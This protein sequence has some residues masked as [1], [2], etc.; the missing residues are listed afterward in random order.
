MSRVVRPEDFM[1]C[2]RESNCCGRRD[3]RRRGGPGLRDAAAQSFRRSFAKIREKLKWRRDG[4]TAGR[5]EFNK[6]RSLVKT[7]PS[8]TNGI[9]SLRHAFPPPTRNFRVLNLYK[10]LD[11]SLCFDISRR[12]SARTRVYGKARGYGARQPEPFTSDEKYRA[13]DTSDVTPALFNSALSF[14]V[15]FFIP[16]S[17]HHSYTFLIT[18]YA[19][20][21]RRDV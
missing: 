1:R 8:H 20:S 15:F 9:V 21:P 10:C 12:R 4:R 7:R 11:F 3:E 17:F 14:L 16:L 5:D 2:K 19:Y 6:Y 18:K 13:A